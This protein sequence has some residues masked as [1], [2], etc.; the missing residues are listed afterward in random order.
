MGSIC[1]GDPLQILGIGSVL[2]EAA[3]SH[4]SAAGTAEVAAVQVWAQC[5]VGRSQE[6]K[7]KT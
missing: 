1:R 6:A 5:W 4:C 3:V 7:D 2:W